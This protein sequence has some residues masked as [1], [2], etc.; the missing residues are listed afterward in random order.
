MAFQFNVKPLP[1]KIND[2]TAIAYSH[3]GLGLGIRIAP[4]VLCQ[5]LTLDRLRLGYL[6]PD[7]E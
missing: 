7:L 3:H 2:L 5:N 4:I 1:L 6:D